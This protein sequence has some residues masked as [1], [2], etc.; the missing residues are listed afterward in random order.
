MNVFLF[1][2]EGYAMIT[3]PE[4]PLAPLMALPAPL[5]APPPPPV[6]VSPAVVI[7][8]EKLDPL[9]PP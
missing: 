2:Y 6:L 5:P 4:P 9:P 8:G 3:I 7:L 1:I